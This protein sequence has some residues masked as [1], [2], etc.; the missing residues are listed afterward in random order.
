MKTAAAPI[1]CALLATGCMFTRLERDLEKLS[2]L[3]VIQGEV[4][5]TEDRYDPLVVVL[6]GSSPEHTLDYFVLPRPGPYFFAVPAGSYRVAVFEDRNGDLTY[7]PG[8]EPAALYDSGSAIT[9]ATADRLE[10]IDLA[11]DTE[12]LAPAELTT[13][14]LATSSRG[15]GQL[16]EAQLGTVVSLDDPR[17]SDENAKLGLWHPARF[18]AEAGYGVYFLEEFDPHKI[19]V[20]FVHGALGTPRDFA[21]LVSRL[22][23]RR[24]Q[25]WLVYYPTALDLSTTA[26]SIN[27]LLFRLHAQYDFDEIA[28][29][30]HSM[31][32]L[33][34]RAA[35]NQVTAH[36]PGRRLVALPAFVTISTPWNGHKAA[37][38]GAEH[39]PVPAPS[40]SSMSPGSEFLRELRETKLP[41]ETSYYL[42]FSYRGGRSGVLDE[43]NDDSVA[44]SSELALDLQRQA[45]RVVGFDESHTSI[46]NSEA[47]ATALDEVLAKVAS[48]NHELTA[49]AR[50]P[51]SSSIATASPAPVAPSWTSRL[52]R[53]DQIA[54]WP[55]LARPPEGPP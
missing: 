48:A 33:V 52:P 7:Q 3:A 8:S 29:V 5:Q 23:R 49:L 31:G 28:L 42:F 18:I 34:S 21:F 24:F 4:T 46:L 37:A 44:L 54:L 16:P 17:F 6:E 41:P 12:R 38:L 13:E 39:A 19:P 40:W 15:V 25:P 53:G 10:G 1:A 32:G 2:A 30:A 47:V 55:A 27:R 50:Q 9:L 43:N 36:L 22:D 11:L 14:N 20:L 51:D 45:T 35:I 26:R